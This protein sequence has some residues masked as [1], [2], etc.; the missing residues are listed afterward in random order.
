MKTNDTNPEFILMMKRLGELIQ[1]KRVEKGMS[2]TQ[3]A[4]AS[5]HRV[6]ILRQLECGENDNIQ[7][8]QSVCGVLDM[9]FIELLKAAKHHD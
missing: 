4:K 7:I 9:N 3:L 5:H 8:I 2:I 1:A 6:S